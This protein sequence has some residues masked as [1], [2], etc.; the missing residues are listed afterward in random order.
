M[1]R[2][3]AAP[4]VRPLARGEAATAV[5]WAAA[6]GWNPGLADLD[7][8]LAQDPGLFLGAF[9][10]DRLAS[11]IGATR[12]GEAFG[13]VGFYIARPEARG[14]GHG[15]AVWRAGMARLAGRVVGLDGVV[16]QQENYR[17][18]GFAPAWRNIRFGGT[19]PSPP[20]GEARPPGGARVVPAASVPLAEVEALDA[21]VFPAPRPDF[22]RAWLSAP[23]HA[24]LAI[25]RDGAAVGF[26]AIRPCRVGHKVGPLVA[27]DARDAGA[28]LAALLRARADAGGPVFL[29]APEPNR[30][31]TA[32]AEGLGLA[33]AFET[34]RMYTGPAPL[35]RPGRL[36][37][38]ATFELG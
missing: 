31:A 36:F 20:P 17:R 13:F 8:V 30:A 6:E 34:A 18:S 19:V 12:Y 38:V 10:G 3:A 15:L 5:D 1:P 25:V 14:R 4:V 29:D 22:L 26:G 33:P 35:A 11:V 16:A 24:A 21:S 9:E 28:L 2:D 37:G 7:A 23:G 32:L 27:G